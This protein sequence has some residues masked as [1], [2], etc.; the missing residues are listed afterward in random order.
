MRGVVR[1]ATKQLVHN[2]KETQQAVVHPMHFGGSLLFIVVLR[3]A[4]PVLLIAD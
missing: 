4:N 1:L 3:A 2:A